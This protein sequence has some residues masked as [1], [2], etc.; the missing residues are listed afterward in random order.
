MSSDVLDVLK[1]EALAGDGTSDHLDGLLNQT[2][3]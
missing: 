2:G 1:R 3:V